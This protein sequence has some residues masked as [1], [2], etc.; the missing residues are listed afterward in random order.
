MSKTTDELDMNQALLSQKLDFITSE[1]AEIK[2]RVSNHFV[3]KE[4]FEPYKRLI[5]GLVAIVMTS[6]FGALLTLI[7]IK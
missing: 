1:L 5:Q 3:S 2:V 7:L 6:V 4:E